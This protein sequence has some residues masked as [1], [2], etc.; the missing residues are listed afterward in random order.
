M[1]KQTALVAVLTA[2]QAFAP[3]QATAALLRAALQ[4]GNPVR[5]AS[6][7]SVPS[8][9]NYQAVFVELGPKM[10]TAASYLSSLTP[11]TIGPAI[12]EGSFP[13]TVNGKS[14]FLT[15]EFAPDDVGIWRVES[16]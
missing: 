15:I 11:L 1:L 16:W 14:G 2:T 12:T 6:L 13:A 4:S 9:A 7:F 5:A 8:R 10:S 3:M